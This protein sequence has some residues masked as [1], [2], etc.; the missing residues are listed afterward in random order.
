ME[1][2]RTSSVSPT[3]AR[4]SG[5]IDIS[6]P[7]RNA[8]VHWPTDS[9]PRVERIQD[10]DRG[11]PVTLTELTIISHTG[12]HIDAPLHFI[13]HGGTIDEMPLGTTVGP[14]RVIEIKDGESIKPEELALH[15]IRRGQRVLFKTRNSSRVYRTDD[16]IEDYVFLTIEAARF[17][18]EKG[19]RLVGIDCL[20]VGTITDRENLHETHRTLL[21]G[22][23][24][25]LEGLDLSRVE[26]GSYDLVCLP[27][28]LARGDGSPARAI[29]RAR[30]PRRS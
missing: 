9:P 16:F 6:L 25:I 11:D 8:M 14:A 28:R 20:S 3:S 5:W 29:V 17:L 2:A 12:T 22:G 23:I 24:Y 13:P 18:V 19:V 26:A 15:H 27:L 1:L 4:D 10:V 7:L 21:S 30:N